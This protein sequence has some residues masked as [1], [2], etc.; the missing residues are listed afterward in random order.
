MFCPNC[1][2]QSDDNAAFCE[3]CGA[4]LNAPP[5]PPGQPP[6]QGGQQQQ[7]YQSSQQHYQSGPP[8]GET[9]VCAIWSLVLG[10]LSLVCCGCFSAIPAVICGHIALNQIKESGDTQG[11]R[12][13]AIAGLVLGYGLIA[14]TIIILIVYVIAIAANP[15]IL[16][17]FNDAFRGLNY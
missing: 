11:G 3:S 5:P 8:Q 14:L 12:G 2:K 6:Y 4:S 9:N 15:E 7:Q 16:D 1:G 13:M 10:I 17:E